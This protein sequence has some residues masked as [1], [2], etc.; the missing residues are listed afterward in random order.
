MPRKPKVKFKDLRTIRRP[1]KPEPDLCFYHWSPTKNRDNIFRKGLE[2]NKRSVGGDWNPRYIC[3]S[4]E[5]NLAWSLS[6]NMHP[7]IPSWD[8]WMCYV[9]H[10]TSF[11]SYEVWL[12]THTFTKR[13][14][15]KEYRVYT[16]VF[17]RDLIYIATREPIRR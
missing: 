10:Q 8:L 11:D 12:D 1:D 16:R 9:A 14:Y 4:D 7:E 15:I 5:P 17:K 3:F 13:H 6:G 2:T